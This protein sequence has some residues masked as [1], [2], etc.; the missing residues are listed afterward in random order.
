MTKSELET[1][2]IKSMARLNEIADIE[3]DLTDA[4]RS[5][6]GTLETEYRDSGVKL[7]A[8]LTG[9]TPN[10]KSPNVKRRR[11]ALS[12]ATPKRAKGSNCAQNWAG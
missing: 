7:A 9:K 8:L 6:A 12:R 1:R 5:E 4:I 3:G 10:G 11:L 2:R